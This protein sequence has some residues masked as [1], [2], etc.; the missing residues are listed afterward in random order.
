VYV[1]S[2]RLNLRGRV[3]NGC[4]PAAASAS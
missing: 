1:G 2:I 4:L 3:P